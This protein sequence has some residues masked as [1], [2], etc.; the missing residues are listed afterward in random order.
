MEGRLKWPRSANN[1]ST[2]ARAEGQ[3]QHGCKFPLA[4]SKGGMQTL[5]DVGPRMLSVNTAPF[6]VAS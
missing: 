2:P 3:S 4:Y 1:A 6:P 5:V